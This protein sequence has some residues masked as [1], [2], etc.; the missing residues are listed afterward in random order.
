MSD[1]PP[2]K[3]QREI[4]DAEMY[5]SEDEE[6]VREFFS[7]EPAEADREVHETFESLSLS[8]PLQRALR[9]LGYVQPT[10]VQARCIPMALLGRDVCGSCHTGGGK[11]AA[12][13]LPIL[14]RLL[15]RDRRFAVTRVLI[16][17]PTRE[18]AVQTHSVMETLGA[19]MDA[20][21]ALV[22]GGL[23]AAKQQMDLRAIPD[24]VVATPGRLIDLL[25][26]AATITLDT[27]EI[28]V[29]DEADRLLDLGFRDELH[30]IIND[31][32]KSR[33]TMLFSATM[34]DQVD[35]L[36]SLSLRK[37]VRVSVDRKMEVA[38]RLTQEFVRVKLGQESQREAMLLALCT[39][40]FTS[41]TLIFVR[42]KRTAHR[43][44]LIFGLAGLQAAELHGNMS[45]TARLES[46]ESFREGKV[47]HLIATDIAARGL[48]ILGIETVINYELPS[49]ISSYVHRVGRTA[50]AGRS[51]RAVSLVT[52]GDRKLLRQIVKTARESVKSRVIA[53]DAVDACFDQVTAMEQDL[54][55][56]EHEEGEERVMRK[57]EMEVTK[58]E[59]M[60]THA[61]EISMRPAK[62]WFQND[63]EKLA[64]KLKAREAH[65]A[66]ER[67]EA[68]E[69]P[70]AAEK[71][72]RKDKKVDPRV[73]KMARHLQE[74]KKARS[75]SAKSE[76]ETNFRMVKAAKRTLKKSGAGAAHEVKSGQKRSKSAIKKADKSKSPKRK[77]AGGGGGGSFAS[78]LSLIHI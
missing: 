6:R 65:E 21:I 75:S 25:R 31:C 8:R 15:H 66:A 12:F 72:S 13:A 56:L 43:I 67:G 58:A 51:G 68:I 60:M 42:Q 52:E 27:I 70:S 62:T 30:Q 59:N 29:L 44:R 41:K 46:L 57:A 36:V 38:N 11:T 20:R 45:Q 53:R 28:L 24:I 63:K 18:L 71:P 48:D 34:T 26:N 78:E 47:T 14:E 40:T 64:V 61:E 2:A 32:P 9:D 1:M 4:T 77:K 69:G 5:D 55:Q 73:A 23:S 54:E 22:V 7:A 76:R 16:L 49:Q 19:H 37:P 39:R 35:A 17:S 33:Q 50:R 10:A 3:P 74:Q